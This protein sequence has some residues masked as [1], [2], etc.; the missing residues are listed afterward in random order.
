MLFSDWEWLSKD[1]L[2]L[3]AR[4]WMPE[5]APRALVCLVHGHGEHSGRYQHVAQAFVAHGYGLMG[6]DLRGH[7]NSEGQRGHTPTYEHLMDDLA[8]FLQSM[9][10]E[11]PN[12]PIFLYGHSMG[13]NL[14]INYVLRMPHTLRGLIAT[15]PWLKLAFEPPASKLAL[16]KMMDSISPAFMQPSGLE[17]SALARDSEVVRQYVYDT[18]V[19]DKISVRMFYGMYHAG[20]WAL[21]RADGLNLPTLLMHGSED[22][23]TSCSAS[24]A[25]VSGAP[26]EKMT[27]REW[28]GFYH[29]IHNEPEKEQVIATMINW[30]NDQ[31][32][33]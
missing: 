33:A 29:E 18:L 11:Y 3:Y 30:L 17:T 10:Q 19:H 7:G 20:L 1:G 23:L 24:R 25:F 13:G 22:R 4:R 28:D 14:V 12:L 2:K 27:F 15:G 21:D 9:H 5:E 6:F 8:A 31:M 16:G 26:A 32:R